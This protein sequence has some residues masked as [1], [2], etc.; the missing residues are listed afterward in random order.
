MNRLLVLVALVAP[1]WAHAEKRAMPDY[2]GR[3][4]AELDAEPWPIWVPRVVLA[5]LYAVHEYVVRR[6]LGALAA[7]AERDRWPTR[8]LEALT[9]G[10]DGKYLVLPSAFYDFGLR[11]SAGIDL[12]FTDLGAA[13]NHLGVH[14]ATGGAEFLSATLSL[15]ALH[16]CAPPPR[17]ALRA[18]FARDTDL[19]P[20]SVPCR[21]DPTPTDPARLTC[22][23]RAYESPQVWD[24]VDNTLFAPLSRWLAV[25]HR[26]EAVNANSLDEV[27]DSA[28]FTNRIGAGA[29]AELATGACRPEDRLPAEVADAAWVIDRG[30]DN[31]ASL[32]FRVDVP[33]KGRYFLKADPADQPERA[34]AASVIG[35]LLYHAA[36]FEVTCEQIV[37]VRRGQLRLTPGLV[38]T[39]N[40]GA[41]RPFDDRAL[42]AVL[43]SAS[44]RDGLAR[45][46]ASRWLPGVT[47]GPFRYEGVREDDPN[48][49][50]PHEDRRELRGA[51]LL[52]AWVN[53]WDSREQNSMDVG[54]AADPARPRSSPGFVRHH[55]L[56]TSDILGQLSSERGLAERLGHAYYFDVQALILDFVTFGAL[57]RPWDSA[58]PVAGR[59]K[60]GYFTARDFDPERWKGAYPNPAFLRMTERDAAWMARIIARFDPAAIRAIVAAG[61]LGDP[62]DVD[63]LTGVLV[64]RQRRILAR[65]LTR[66][67]PVADVRAADGRICAVDLARRHGLAAR[68]AYTVVEHT[69]RARFVIAAEPGPDGAVCFAPRSLA[70]ADLADDAADRLVIFRVD[71]G[72]AAGPLEIHAYDLG[73]RG[74]RV[75]GLRRPA[76]EPRS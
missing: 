65:Y 46:E 9:F 70:P 50:V 26:G 33:G 1:A 52:A 35:A 14:A 49:I 15:L 5:P 68:Y 32:G 7:R 31:G 72:T 6:L 12:S 34:S 43:A 54:L 41:R 8:V 4:N 16:A 20:V 51:R 3:G 23:P 21:A 40:T 38:T 76:R 55:V 11:P 71:N 36:G 58:A 62:T 73:P 45:M 27:A 64:E 28:W 25:E 10:P 61:Q 63:Y 37:Y 17:F 39:D 53:H 48:D 42:A 74:M 24:Q 18:P 59:E 75:V 57:D 30:K 44:Q 29:T 69:A 66:R 47:L 2:D 22:A 67:S 13:G 60:F 19:D 56:D